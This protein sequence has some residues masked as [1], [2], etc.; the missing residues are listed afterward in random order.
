MVSFLLLLCLVP[1]LA[2]SR[3]LGWEWGACSESCPSRTCLVPRCSPL[4][5]SQPHLS[6]RCPKGC[7]SAWW[8]HGTGSGVCWEGAA[9]QPQLQLQ[10]TGPARA[11]EEVDVIGLTWEPPT[12]V[13]SP[14]VDMREMTVISHCA[15]CSTSSLL[16]S[17]GLW[18][19]TCCFQSWE[20][21]G[22]GPVASG[23]SLSSGEM[24][25]DLLLLFL[26]V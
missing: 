26:F 12:H 8:G 4:V 9:G 1:S 15:P 6:Q 24:I 18:L 19:L 10:G 2:Y 5:V 13:P 20:G 7:G 22:M 14:S 17:Q 3:I 11:G 16:L 21:V 23:R 25:P